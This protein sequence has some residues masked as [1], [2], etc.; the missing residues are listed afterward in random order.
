MLDARM[1]IEHSLGLSIKVFWTK[2]CGTAVPKDLDDLSCG[3][4]L[5]PQLSVLY[6]ILHIFSTKMW[7]VKGGDRKS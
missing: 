7:F 4:G 1:V 2:L 5:L 3:R 6:H